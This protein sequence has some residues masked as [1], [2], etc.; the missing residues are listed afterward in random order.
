[1]L[2]RVS[3]AAVRPVVSAIPASPRGV[4][5]TRRA[6]AGALAAFSPALPGSRIEPCSA[7]LA[8]GTRL[9]GEWVR[10]PGVGSGDSVLLY[11]HG[12]G[13]AICSARTH[14]GI[15][16]RLSAGIGIPVF[17]CD[18]RLAPRHRFPAAAQDVRAAYDWL[19][20]Q[21]Y[22]PERIVLA[23][24]SAGGHLS[25]ILVAELL[26][27][28]L[29]P[30]AGMLLLSPLADPTFGLARE[31]ERARRDPLVS[32]AR[33][34]KLLE[35]YTRGADPA[36]PRLAVSIPHDRDWPRTLIQAG[37][38]EML[39]ADAEWLDRELRQAGADCELTIWDEQMHVFQAFA[40]VNPAAR[41]ALAEGSAF[42]RTALRPGE[43]TV[44]A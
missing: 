22:P 6:A 13:Y 24:D 5:L 44:P 4:W 16:S 2:T 38:A 27:A 3:T 20:A 28:G 36:D 14:R 37:G 25:V 31:R 17:S 23:G 18:Y 40:T 39:A 43:R 35:L 26:R 41:R 7:P 9:R 8:G 12:S 1:M 33:A 15:T 34:A 11:V 21:G 32:A 10:A 29:S 30:P 19:R 42:L